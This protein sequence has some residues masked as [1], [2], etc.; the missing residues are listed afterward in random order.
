MIGGESVMVC[1]TDLDHDRLMSRSC[2]SRVPV[3]TLLIMQR[4][5]IL[6]DGVTDLID[7]LIR[8]VWPGCTQYLAAIVSFDATCILLGLP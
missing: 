2:E 5:R 6:V 3:M 8:I 7:S 1:M 4:V